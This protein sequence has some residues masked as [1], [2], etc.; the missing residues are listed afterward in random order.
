[1]RVSYSST[2]DSGLSPTGV[3]GGPGHPPAPRRARA[4]LTAA[5][6][7]FEEETLRRQRALYE[8]NEGMP[9]LPV[10]KS[11]GGKPGRARRAAADAPWG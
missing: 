10:L 11:G 2:W 7:E 1:V 4:A 6:A 3:S 8:Q 9:L 5:R